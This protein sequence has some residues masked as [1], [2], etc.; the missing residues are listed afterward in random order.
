MPVITGFQDHMIVVTRYVTK[1][2]YFID[3]GRAMYRCYWL[4]DDIMTT[5]FT[6]HI[7]S[8]T[9]MYLLSGYS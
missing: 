2:Y 5:S 6:L 7:F 9:Y 4:V 8:N 1:R 3:P